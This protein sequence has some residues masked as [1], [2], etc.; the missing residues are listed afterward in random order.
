M[1]KIWLALIVLILSDVTGSLCFAR[2]MKQI[3]AAR[4]QVQDLRSLS[5]HILMTPLVSIGVFFLAIQFLMYI[6]LLSWADLS[7]VL[8]AT[9]LTDPVNV[10]GSR[11][12]LKE[13]VTVIRWTGV[14]IICLGVYL[15]TKS[16]D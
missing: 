13:K 1:M 16:A 9:A 2:G 11:L 15:I 14:F 5:R 7:F 3:G 4:L 8:P 6:A 12:I 10:L